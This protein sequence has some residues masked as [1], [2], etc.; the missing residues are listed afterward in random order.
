MG[1]AAVLPACATT[2]PAPAT[3]PEAG[4]GTSEAVAAPTV[5]G[6]LDIWTFPMTEDDQGMIW[7]PLM[8]KFKAEFPDVKTTIEILPWGGPAKIC[9]PLSAGQA[10]DMPPTT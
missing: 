4:S 2:T 1:V 10:P 3:A 9:S 6:A 7:D 8:E 5:A